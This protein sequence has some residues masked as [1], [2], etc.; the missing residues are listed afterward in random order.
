MK[1]FA[2]LVS[3]L[4]WSGLPSACRGHGEHETDRQWSKEELAELEAKWGAEVS[5]PMPP[6]EA[7]LTSYV[8]PAL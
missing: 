8:G 1:S 6:L 5:P 4:L 7:R 3:L 2:A